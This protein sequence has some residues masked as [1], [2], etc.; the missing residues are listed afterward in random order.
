[1]DSNPCTDDFCVPETGD[2]RNEPIDCNCTDDGRVVGNPCAYCWCSASAGSCG[3]TPVDCDDHDET[4]T[5]AC[6][7]AVID[8]DHSAAVC[9]HRRK[10]CN[11]TDLCL[12]TY[13]D[14]ITGECVSVPRSCPVYADKC[15]V[16]GQCDPETGVCPIRRTS[17]PS[18]DACAP[19]RC[20]PATGLCVPD[21]PVVCDVEDDPCSVGTCTDGECH[22]AAVDCG[23]SSQGPCWDRMCI[24]AAGGC[25]D[26]PADCSDHIGC[27][28]DWCEADTGVCRHAEAASCAAA[29]MPC[30]PCTCDLATGACTC[31]PVNCTS[32]SPCFVGWC[33]PETGAC[34]ET[35]RCPTG[36]IDECTVAYCDETAADL[37]KTGPAVD[38]SDPSPCVTSRCVPGIG[39][40]RSSKV[41][42]SCDPCM[43]SGCSDE[44]GGCYEV[45]KTCDDGIAETVD[46][47]DGN[48]TCRH[49]RRFPCEDHLHCTD[50]IIDPATGECFHIFR[51][52]PPPVG[53][54][55]LPD[56]CEIGTC[57][58]EDGGECVYTRTSCDADDPDL[59][60]TSVCD[61]ATGSCVPGPS[62][63]CDDCMPC[64]RD[65]CDEAGTGRCVH[66]LKSCDD[67][68]P[69]TIDRC[70]DQGTCEHKRKSCSDGYGRCLL[71]PLTTHTTGTRAR[72]TGATTPPGNAPTLRPSTA[73]RSPRHRAP[74]A[75]ACV[76][77]GGA[78]AT[79]ETAP[80]ASSALPT[81]ASSPLASACTSRRRASRCRASRRRATRPTGPACTRRSSATTASLIR[82]TGARR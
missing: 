33:H 59:C 2:C 24:A 52:C 22:Y 54:D 67:F 53:E 7:V 25:V 1:M 10:E 8:D 48:G 56:L 19:D 34:M 45:P 61:S 80:T 70:T 14:P 20:E 17:C 9:T 77:P 81:S 41:C 4:T 28:D 27:T 16:V 29:S 35:P 69:C 79:R 82:T 40:V 23:A 73:P 66:E 15:I 38:C 72:S 12:R 58:E 46:W 18:D 74:T 42:S 47:C 78:R 31:T 13:L 57:S 55:S 62:K 36:P 6:V 71:P 30:T 5:D 21:E 68:L 60:T 32:P 44:L 64:T 11:A 37:C 49:R 63:S 50:D 51:T 3:S 26:V 75:S 76:R 43:I 65:Y 39:C